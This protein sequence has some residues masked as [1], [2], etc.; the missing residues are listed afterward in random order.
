MGGALIRFV[1]E[2]NAIE[3]ILREPYETELQAHL[4]FLAGDVS[5]EALERFVSVVQPDAALRRK[6]GMN[7]R[8]GTYVAPRG[9]QVKGFCRTACKTQWNSAARALAR[10]MEER[11]IV[12]LA[13]R[14]KNRVRESEGDS[15]A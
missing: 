15:S 6:A 10:T 2:S 8:V 7:G 12:R 13:D 4:R 14:W 3:G 9:D 11:G 5:V 1:T